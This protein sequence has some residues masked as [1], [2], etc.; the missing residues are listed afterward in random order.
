MKTKNGYEEAGQKSV[1][2][3]SYIKGK[4]GKV[5]RNISFECLESKW[6]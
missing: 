4:F 6:F 5:I 1:S 2:S 3:E